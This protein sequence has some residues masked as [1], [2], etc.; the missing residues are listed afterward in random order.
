MKN[1]YKEAHANHLLRELSKEMFGDGWSSYA[2]YCAYLKLIANIQQKELKKQ[3]KMDNLLSFDEVMGKEKNKQD[4]LVSVNLTNRFFS[5]FDWRCKC[6]FQSSVIGHRDHN[7]G[8]MS[9]E[10]F[11]FF[12]RL[13]HWFMPCLWKHL[14]NL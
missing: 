11:D 10:Q 6:L 3:K 8:I 2:L 14:S 12:V 9:M 4:E 1:I 5:V 7:Q 13:A